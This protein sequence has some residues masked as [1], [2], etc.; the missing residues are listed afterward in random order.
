LSFWQGSKKP[1]AQMVRPPFAG[2]D[3]LHAIQEVALDLKAHAADPGDRV[4]C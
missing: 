2:G 4:A 1:K 3:A